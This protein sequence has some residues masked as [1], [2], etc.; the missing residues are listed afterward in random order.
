MKTLI[1]LC[2]IN[3]TVGALERNAAKIATYAREAAKSGASI[4]LFPE[5][6][7]SGYPPEDLV[8]KRH[9][10]RDCWQRLK[11]LEKILPTQA[12]VAVGVPQ[13][14]DPH[15]HN[16]AA[17]FQGGHIVG[18]Y[19][20]MVLP[21]YGVFDEK[22]LFKPGRMPMIIQTGSTRIG[23]HICEDSWY[24]D[25]DSVQLLKDSD[26]NLLINLS[27]SPYHRQKRLLREQVLRQ[28]GLFLNCPV[29]Y[30]NLVGGQDELVFDGGSLVMDRTG[31]LIGRA[32]QFEESLVYAQLE[33]DNQARLLEEDPASPLRRIINVPPLPEPK[34]SAA[35]KNHS[36]IEPFR[37]DIA[38]VY[39][40]LKL[41]LRDYVDKNGFSKTVIALSGGIDSALVAAVAV[42]SL[43]AE[44]VTG[45]TMP[46]RFSSE[47]TRSDA[48]TLARNLG[49]PFQT[50]AIENMHTTALEQLAPLWPDHD[51]DIT[52]EN[53]QARIRGMIIMALSNKF[54]WLV[55]A[56]GNKSELA[57]GYCTLYGDMVGG[58]ALIKDV[59]KTLVYELCIWR[60]TQSDTPVIPPSI[61]E[62]PPTAELRPDQR[63]SDSLPPYDLLDGI[64]ERYV[65]K[66]MG[67]DDICSEGFD[68]D[69]V[70]RVARMIDAS[71]YKRR[72]GAP[73]VKITPK[74]FG[75]D[76]RM[77]LT[78][79]YRERAKGATD[80]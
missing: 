56:T 57:T 43:G 44:R 59:P 66:D 31:Q 65:E 40:A 12:L 1:A 72:Q 61:I 26:L 18:L 39:E 69:T 46:S 74:A 52:E 49:I 62:R 42:D 33:T 48:R 9:F 55:L 4:I 38:E 36:V 73:G 37:D 51:E 27:A 54:G 7:L 24:K 70:T 64:I 19:H 15:L 47:E 3:P 25:R 22:R 45:V 50:V 76:R 28:T 79:A 35:S 34:L 5:L 53:L 75:R 17:V 77:P 30:C 60:N 29:A 63:D 78:N 13:F 16:A 6:A 20:K 32:K 8:L 68:P 23:V 71:E 58:F 41:G 14:V 21:N 11:L 10:I 80:S 67:V 2:Q